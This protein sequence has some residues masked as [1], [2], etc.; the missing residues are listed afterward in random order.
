MKRVGRLTYFA[1][2]CLFRLRSPREVEVDKRPLPRDVDRET[3]PAGGKDEP[4]PNN[5][6]VENEAAVKGNVEEEVEATPCISEAAG[7]TVQRRRFAE[8]GCG[9]TTLPL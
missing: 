3:R 5:G 8:G 6:E 1:P 7:A 9:E 4:A 2:P